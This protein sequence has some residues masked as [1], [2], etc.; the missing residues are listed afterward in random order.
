MLIDGY[1][2]LLAIPQKTMGGWVDSNQG[3]CAVSV[4]VCRGSHT[5]KIKQK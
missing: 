5:K 1:K 4:G 2:Q 3:K